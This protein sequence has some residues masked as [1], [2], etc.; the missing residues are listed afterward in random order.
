MLKSQAGSA[1]ILGIMVMLFLVIASAGLLPWLTNETRMAT[2]GRD[3]LEAEYAAEAGAK[4]AANEFNKI[5]VSQSPDWSWLNTDRP[6]TND[7]NT[8]KYN[9]LI[10]VS[11]DAGKT[12]VTPVTTANNTYVVQS[13]GT[14][15]RAVKTVSVNVSVTGGGG[16]GTKSSSDPNSPFHY[17]AYSGNNLNLSKT[18]AINGANYTAA[19]QI[20]GSNGGSGKPVADPGVVFPAYAALTSYNDPGRPVNKPPVSGNKYTLDMNS[21]LSNT[22]LVIDG[23]LEISRNVNFDNV[24]LYVNGKITFDGGGV[25]FNGSNFIVANGNLDAKDDINFGNSVVVS[26]GVL[27][28]RSINIQ[29]SIVSQGDELFKGNTNITYNQSLVDS[30]IKPSASGNASA[31][32]QGGSWTLQ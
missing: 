14:V 22:T 6:F 7:V 8:K 11:G 15:G 18:G 5:N 23:N 19:N 10:Y 20:I 26:Y 4:R 17:A 30:F 31:T 1:T 16:G 12:P 13:T 3:V 29:G 2:R 28:V 27:D 32:I 24:T 25:N 9:V 21:N